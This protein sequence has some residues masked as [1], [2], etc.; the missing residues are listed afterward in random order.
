MQAQEPSVVALPARKKAPPTRPSSRARWWRRNLAYFVFLAPWLLGFLLWTGGPL[1]AS[2][3]LSLTQYDILMPP[4]WVGFNNYVQLFN[5]DLFWQALKVTSIYT[6]FGVPLLMATSLGLA[7][8]LNQKVPG[9]SVF[10]T[11]FYLPTVRLG[12][13][14]A[15]RLAPPPNPIRSHRPLSDR[16]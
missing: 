2:V 16:P 14:R 13:G 10:R 1:I 15:A 7:V 5:D 9:L 11:I 3:Y 8:M 6:F 4:K 12:Q